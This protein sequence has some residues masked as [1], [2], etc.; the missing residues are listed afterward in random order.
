MIPGTIFERRPSRIRCMLLHII[1]SRPT[2]LYPPILGDQQGEAT[3]GEATEGEA[4]EGQRV[5]QR[6][7]QR[8][9]RQVER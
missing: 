8:V 7:W 2:Q 4:T 3:E 9:G 6:V 5:W 1:R